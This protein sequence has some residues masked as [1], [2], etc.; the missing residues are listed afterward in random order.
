[1]RFRPLNSDTPFERWPHFDPG[2]YIDFNPSFVRLPSGEAFAVIRRDRVPPVPGKGTV[3][4]VAVDDAMRPAG[5]P[6]ALITDG[7]DPRAVCVGQ[8]VLVFYVLFERDDAGRITG[9]SMVLAEFEPGAGG[10]APKGHFKLP[11]YPLGGAP[12]GGN[13]GW[14]KNW[15][16]F[17]ISAT[18]VGLIYSHD[19]WQVIVLNVDPA[20][21]ERRF[22]KA[23]RAEGLHWAYGGVRG[24]TPPLR[25]GAGALITFF[26]SSEV[27]G[28]RKSYMAGACV[29]ADTPPYQ[30]LRSTAD[31]LLVSPYH[32]G[33]HRHG[34][35]VAASVIFPL[36]AEA[37][38]RDAAAHGVRLLCGIDDGE[39]GSIVI[40]ADALRERL[41][42]WPPPPAPTLAARDDSRRALQAPL[43]LQPPGADAPAWP[44][45]RFLEQAAGSGRT[46]LDVGS[47]SGLFGSGLA[48]GY[49]QVESV[50]LGAD[51]ARW[52]VRNAALNALGNVTVHLPHGAAPAGALHEA[53]A[54]V[55]RAPW[56]ASALDAAGFAAVDLITIDS[57]DCAAL[58]AGL[59]HTVERDLPVLLLQ[60]AAD[61]SDRAH[62]GALL[63]ALGYTMEAIFPRT[64]RALLCVHPTR[65]AALAWF[66]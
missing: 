50:A 53:A 29:F 3:W 5:R 56:A 54:A 37:V 45:L 21:T 16:P 46:L 30:P 38:R 13:P 41:Q 20:S 9:T 17:V 32:G 34:W 51:A 7:E 58:L 52:R 40:P 42:A 12:P 19:P 39:I 48:A 49:A 63:A 55:A 66:V 4:A 28:S 25:F 22:E 57:D 60:T 6:F 62:I 1:M 11:K 10:W 27:L 35:A 23:Y 2:A 47:D 33:M 44:L 65:R 59:R 15:V 18:Q 64:P 26:H 43:L 31:P 14:E 61:G 24:G 36:G 8:R